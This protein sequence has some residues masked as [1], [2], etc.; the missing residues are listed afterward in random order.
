L[1]SAKRLSGDSHASSLS[2]SSSSSS[3]SAANQL[4]VSVSRENVVVGVPVHSSKS[5]STQQS[6]SPAESLKTLDDGE[7][8]QLLQVVLGQPLGSH[9]PYSESSLHTALSEWRRRRSAWERRAL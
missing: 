9:S 6:L 7:L 2:S 8:F 1:D 4:R 3:S 5:D